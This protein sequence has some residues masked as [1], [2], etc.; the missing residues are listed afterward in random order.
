M[1]QAH[2]NH[3]R[4]I[5]KEITKPS[6]FCSCQTSLHNART[7]DQSKTYLRRTIRS[8]TDRGS[9]IQT[10][11]GPYNECEG[12]NC[13]GTNISIQ[14]RFLQLKK[15]ETKTNL[16]EK[17]SIFS[18]DDTKNPLQEILRKKLNEQVYLNNRIRRLSTK[19]SY[20]RIVLNDQTLL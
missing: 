2:S 17:P 14:L 13:H 6:G 7:F 11:I 15:K 19:F 16:A 9:N 5:A 8:E 4:K 12:T 1:C 20:K 18:K 10:N 3:F